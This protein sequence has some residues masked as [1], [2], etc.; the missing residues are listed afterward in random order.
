VHKS[1]GRAA[2]YQADESHDSSIAASNDNPSGTKKGKRK[3]EGAA[4]GGRKR[5]KN[6]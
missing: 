3:A 6:D 1:P 2:K 5:T 4:A